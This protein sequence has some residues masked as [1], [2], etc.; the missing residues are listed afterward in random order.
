MR[1]NLLYCLLFC[2]LFIDCSDKSNN[3]LENKITE[4]IALRKS[5]KIIL[6]AVEETYLKDMAL[7]EKYIDCF[8]NLKSVAIPL[9]FDVLY[10][11]EKLKFF[12][13][14]NSQ[15]TLCELLYKTS[16]ECKELYEV[17][18]KLY[19]FIEIFRKEYRSNL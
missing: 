4:G 19:K 10:L 7:N 9:I 2:N 17:H 6:D 18:D 1:K 3:D 13:V 16:S 14:D 11:E 5:L 12:K 15:K 8:N